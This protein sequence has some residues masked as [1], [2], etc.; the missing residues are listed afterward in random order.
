[1]ADLLSGQC[2][3]IVGRLRPLAVTT[4][5]RWYSLPNVPTLAE[6]LPGYEVELWIGV[7]V[8]KGTPRPIIDR[9]NATINKFLQEP[10]MKKSLEAQGMAPSGGTPEK[11]DKRIRGDYERWVKIVRERNIKPE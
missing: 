10:E 9:F 2:Q 1:M 6:T 5:K 3:L 4:A 8:P 11:F 7:M